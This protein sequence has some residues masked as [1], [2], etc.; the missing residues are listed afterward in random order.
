MSSIVPLSETKVPHSRNYLP[1]YGRLL[2]LWVFGNNV[3]DRLGKVGFTL[4]YLVGGLVALAAHVVVDPSSTVPVVGAS[5]AIAA[6]MGAYLVWYPDARV[7]TLVVFFFI[8]V[9][10]LRAK[11][12][13]GVWFVLQFFTNPNA[14]VAWVAHVGGFG[15]GVLVALAVRAIG[16]PR[17]VAPLG[18]AGPG[19]DR[20]PP[21][22]PPPG[23]PDH[24]SGGRY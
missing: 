19:P 7:R 14:G 23:P 3:E 4:F 15:F 13:L 6:V 9:V 24:R 12:L 11:G 17:D 10:D 21:V 8:T 1:V 2:F 18:P 16:G 5:G 20:W 22:P